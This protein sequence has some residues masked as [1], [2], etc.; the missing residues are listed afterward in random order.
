MKNYRELIAKLFIPLLTILLFA[1]C[2]EDDPAEIVGPA[3]A[4][5]PPGI[6]LVNEG[7][8]GTANA[9]L[10][11]YVPDSNKI[12]NDVYFDAT[13]NPLGDTG[14]SLTLHD[15]LLYIVVNNSDKIEVIDSKNNSPV[16]TIVLPQNSSPRHILFGPN[17][18]GYISNLMSN[19][20]SVYDPETNSIVE[21]IPVGN[22]PEQLYY[23]NNHIYVANSGFGDSNTLTVINISTNIIAG[24]IVVGDGPSAFARI[25]SG[26]FAVLCSGNFGASDPLAE[27]PGQVFY[28]ETQTRTVT[29]SVFIG[30][31]PEHLIPDRDGNLLFKSSTGIDKII[32]SANTVEK[33][34][35][36]GSFYGLQYDV[37][38][39]RIYVT[40]AK[41][42]QQAG[43][44]YVY[45]SGG[46]LLNKFTTGII[47]S[48]MVI[49]D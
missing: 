39:N 32:V 36:N 35:I 7:N 8:F 5:N 24:T 38:R 29:D 49:M 46:M 10:S 21:D 27:T 26:K 42:F 40:D 34:I 16:R 18:K 37:K 45:S 41:D 33:N 47:P 11:F 3:G 2:S 15:D 22:N 6:F 30:G 1:G 48:R 25:N 4:T 43:E 12:I 13:G 31:H 17:G 28:V 9:S 44:L 14:H 23:S 20:V 19:T